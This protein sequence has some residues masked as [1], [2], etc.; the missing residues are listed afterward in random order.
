MTLNNNKFRVCGQWGSVEAAE[1]FEI[2]TYCR[3]PGV[4]VCK[5]VLCESASVLLFTL[6]L[7]MKVCIVSFSMKIV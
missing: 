3:D 4:C 1:Q 5:C 7:A 6:N 2:L